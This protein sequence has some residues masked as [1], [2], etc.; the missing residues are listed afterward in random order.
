MASARIAPIQWL[1]ALAATLVL[2]MHASDRIQSGPVAITGPFVPSVPNLS[3]FG[4]SGVDL[5]FVISGFV[6]AQWLST[7]DRDP[8]RFLAKRWLRIVPLFA[9]VSAV[10]MTIMH[11]PLTMP[12]ALMSITV[13]PLL[14]GGRYHVPALYP[15]W[16]LGFEFVFYAVV[17]VAMLARHHR[18][19]TLFAMTVAVA[20]MGS[21]VHPGWAPARL[22]LNPLL[23]EF[24]LGVAV[25]MAWRRGISA[26]IAKAALV[27]GIMMLAIGIA[28]GLGFPLQLQIV[29]A[30]DGLSGYA[31]TATW[32]IPWTLVVIGVIDTVPGG[33][34]ERIVAQVGDA[35]YSTYL[36]H[37]CLLALLWMV[38]SRIPPV[39]PYAFAAMFVTASTLLG[40]VV[41]RW[42]ERPLLTRLMPPTRARAPAMPEPVVA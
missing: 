33:R 32:G 15:G 23:L 26:P 17:A 10:Y 7:A 25:W 3:A 35:S 4:A 2:M 24:A 34:F 6:M 38:G 29:A 12:A 27:T 42:V 28:V 36:S 11:D 16:T 30:V 22:L 14:D 40:L 39:S 1:R 37:P 31:R 19:E 18:I 13:L 21:V 8:W 20:L 41:H 9:G 5:F